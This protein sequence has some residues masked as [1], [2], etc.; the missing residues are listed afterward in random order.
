MCLQRKPYSLLCIFL[1][2][3]CQ[4][5][6]N[7]DTTPLGPE[8]NIENAVFQNY[9]ENYSYRGKTTIPADSYN[10][11]I[12]LKTNNSYALKYGINPEAIN[13]VTAI[14]INTLLDLKGAAK[15]GDLVND[16]FLFQEGY[17][18]SQLPE[19]ISDFLNSSDGEFESVNHGRLIFTNL[20]K[21][22]VRP[23]KIIE[24][25]DS[26]PCLFRVMIQ[27]E[28]DLELVDTLSVTLIGKG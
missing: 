3:G 19:R 26:I 9:S 24:G 21:I 25:R 12:S 8:F 13:R 11:S 20:Q 18:H 14:E 15:A 16:F 10:I 7:E 28:N 4:N 2:I 5:Y 27:I 17:T 6:D 22:Q 1:L 23:K